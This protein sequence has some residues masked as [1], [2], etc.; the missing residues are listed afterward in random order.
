MAKPPLN[1]DAI[2]EVRK[3]I[4][5]H[6]RDLRIAKGLTQEDLAKEMGIS[7]STIAK[8]ENGKW[9]FSVD[10][11]V[12][13]SHHLDF[14]LFLVDKKSDDDLAKTMRERWNRAHNNN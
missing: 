11:I 14:F 9:A 2:L 5:A 4:G 10:T 13:F 8:I 12:E 7:R 3:L 6:I 1:P